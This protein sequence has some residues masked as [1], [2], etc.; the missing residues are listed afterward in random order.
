M[1]SIERLKKIIIESRDYVQSLSFKDR[2]FEFEKNANYV[3]VGM[4]RAGKTFLIYNL[5][6]ERAREDFLYINFEDERL[7]EFEVADF[8]LLL[9]A[10]GQLFSKK[11]AIY[12]DEIQNIFGWEKFCR[13][14]ADFGYEISITGSNASM[15][16][17][18]IAT[19]LGGRFI[20]KEI[21]SLSFAEFL[22]FNGVKLVPNFEYSKQKSE[23]VRLMDEYM[24]YGGLP[25]C[26]KY[27]DKRN[28]L[29]NIF[30]KV[31]FGDIIARYKLKNEFALRLLIKKMAESVNNETSFN[32]I[33]NILNS[34]NAK[35]GTGT[36]IEYF[37][38]LEESFLVNS[39]SN[40]TSKFAEKESKKKFYFADTGILNLFLIDQKSKLLENLVYIELRRRFQSEIYFYKRIIETDFYVPDHNLLVQVC[41]SVKDYETRERELKSLKYS[42]RELQINESMIITYDEQEE[43]EIAEGKI[44]V[45][46]YWKWVL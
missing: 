1:V 8:D 13:R 3:F 42:M 39:I 11:P 22:S 5:I 23:V 18:E 19:T 15:L 28:Y 41:M 35:V 45:V 46:P 34:S 29:S 37:S 38:Y 9:E 26:I 2:S 44:K 4:R 40:F 17:R 33:K 20:V 24:H 36:L 21:Q 31:F 32:R 30:Q 7:M 6:K 16:S 27:N 14:L 12:F 10:Y 25:E 43:I